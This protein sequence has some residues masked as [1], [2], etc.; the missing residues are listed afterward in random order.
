MNRISLKHLF[1]PKSIR[2]KIKIYWLI[3]GSC[4]AYSISFTLGVG[5]SPFEVALGGDVARLLEAVLSLRLGG[6]CG[7]PVDPTPRPSCALLS[8]RLLK[9][10][11]FL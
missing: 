1:T 9:V 11:N 8:D 4:L 5:G 6:G 3:F 2:D 7:D 10:I